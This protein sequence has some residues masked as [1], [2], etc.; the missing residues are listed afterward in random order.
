MTSSKTKQANI[1]ILMVDQLSGE[2]FADGPADFLH[3]PNLKKTR[4]AL[5]QIQ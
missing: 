2:F 1:L 3:A 4:S 5:C